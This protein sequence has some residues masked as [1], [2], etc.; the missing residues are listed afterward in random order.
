MCG[1]PQHDGD[2]EEEEEG[3]GYGPATST[4]GAEHF[5]PVIATS[6]TMAGVEHRVEHVALALPEPAPEPTNVIAYK[7]P[8]QILLV[9]V[10]SAM[11]KA[12]LSPIEVFFL[13]VN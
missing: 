2:R 6:V 11:A 8:K 12:A 10:K 1:S 7:T 5:G 13:G 3:W 9:V 4:Y